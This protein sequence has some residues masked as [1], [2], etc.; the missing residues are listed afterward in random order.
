MAAPN[1]FGGIETGERLPQYFL[2]RVAFDV[3]RTGRPTGYPALRVKHENCV[4]LDALDQEP[5]LFLT[6]AKPVFSPFAL[7]DVAGHLRESAEI[8][9][10][11]AQRRDH[12]VCPKVRPIYAYA[13]AV[14]LEVAF[15]SRDTQHFFRMA[16][17]NVFWRVET[18]RGLSQYLG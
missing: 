14:F 15:L 10:L 5:K 17:L 16:P 6:F 8:P 13:P 2:G 12:Y 1:V 9:G 3:L 18:G 4:V 11:I 7:R